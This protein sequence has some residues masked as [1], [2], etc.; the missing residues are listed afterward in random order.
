MLVIIGVVIVLFSVIGGFLMEGG[1][2]GV[3]FQPIELLIIGGAAAGS[4]IIS[5]PTPKNVVTN[6]EW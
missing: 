1:H 5:S 3:L 4:L 6:G 2:F